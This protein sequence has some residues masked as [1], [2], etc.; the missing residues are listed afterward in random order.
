MFTNP[1]F[2]I[3]LARQHHRELLADAAPQ[4]L[5]RAA[6][7]PSG[8]NRSVS[9]QPRAARGHPTP[10]KTAQLASRT[11]PTRQVTTRAR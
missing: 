8:A 3:G 9:P 11:P 6:P 2:A 5:T 4:Q 7:A 10:R 1:G